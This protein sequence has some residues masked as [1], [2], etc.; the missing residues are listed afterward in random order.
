MRNEQ[1]AAGGSRRAMD[2]R[3]RARSSSLISYLLSLIFL[4]ASASGCATTKAS[5]TKHEP[6]QVPP[7]P[8]RVIAPAPEPP[9]EATEPEPVPPLPR[10]SRPAAREAAP[11]KSEP[12]STPETPPQVAPETITAPAATPPASA[13]AAGPGAPEL[14]TAG[15]PD[16]AKASRD[17]R[18]VLDR[19]GKLLNS[20]DYR[21]LSNSSKLQY[22]MAKR[23]MEQSE[24]ALKARNYVAAKLMAEKAETIGK[25]LGGH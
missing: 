16:D 9:E 24:D 5:T 18:D 2:C 13:P 17:V 12:K 15:T 19:A 8:P 6:L 11:T 25:E 21:A 23:F 10:A 20:I 22:D 7:A 4:V 14:K 1:G 3:A